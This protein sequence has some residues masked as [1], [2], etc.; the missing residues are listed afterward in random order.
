MIQCTNKKTDLDTTLNSLKT[1][2]EE[3]SKVKENESV[4]ISEKDVEIPDNIYKNI[5]KDLFKYYEGLI[6]KKHP[7]ILTINKFDNEITGFYSYKKIG[8]IINFTGIFENNSFYLREEQ[9]HTDNN[10][11]KIVLYFL[12]DSIIEGKWLKENKMLDI[13]LTEATFPKDIIQIEK[14]QEDSYMQ[15]AK[16]RNENNKVVQVDYF[17]NTWSFIQIKHTNPTIEKK[18]NNTIKKMICNGHFSSIE[19]EKKA[20]IKEEKL[21]LNNIE[22]GFNGTPYFTHNAVSV[23][24]NAYN[25]LELIYSST[26]WAGGTEHYGSDTQLI[27]TLTGN[28][29]QFQDCFIQ[30]AKP[31]ILNLVKKQLREEYMVDEESLKD[32]KLEKMFGITNN[33]ITYSFNK[34]EVSIGATGAP[35]VTI[36]FSELKKY[37]KDNGPFTIFKKI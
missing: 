32:I 22:E 6:D 28:P 17:E 8:E 29:L 16:I 31:V 19:D 11:E 35:F 10:Q 33:G 36:P 14:I 13:T 12:N 4:E 5:P 23:G 30:E 21:N 27:N 25:I 15:K 7:I 37:I 9:E 2:E 24:F 1:K 18:I 20:L 26:S 3:L 34:Y